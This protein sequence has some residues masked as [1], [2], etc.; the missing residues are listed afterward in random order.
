M[1]RKLIARPRADLD[2]IKH[3]VFL[4]E[5]NPQL[6]ARFKLSVK[7]AIAA[8]AKAPRSCSAI[9]F[10]G[11]PDVELRFKRP[12]GFKNYLIYFQVTDDAIIVLRVLHSSQDAQAELRP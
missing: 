10:P 6:A 2:I 8:I 3:F 12:G 4:T 5:L 9:Q 1:K 11:L 7:A